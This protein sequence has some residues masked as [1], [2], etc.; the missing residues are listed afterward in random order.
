MR[1]KVVAHTGAC[2]SGEG[3]LSL[4]LFRPF[5]TVSTR[6]EVC[7]SRV[8]QHGFDAC[9]QAGH[10]VIRRVEA[11][12]VSLVAGQGHIDGDVAV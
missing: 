6:C 9:V 7:I 8:L 10:E 11:L 4:S 1:V 12:G 5:A 2:P 3:S